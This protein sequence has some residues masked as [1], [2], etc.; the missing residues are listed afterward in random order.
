MIEIIAIAYILSLLPAVAIG[1]LFNNQWNKSRFNIATKKYQRQFNFCLV[2][3][4][5][6]TTII[7]IYLLWAF[8]V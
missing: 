4:I 8:P 7:V 5:A 2:T 3:A 6:V 1:V